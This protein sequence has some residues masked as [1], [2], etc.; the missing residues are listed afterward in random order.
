MIWTR[1]TRPPDLTV[2]I[3]RWLG[4]V[5]FEE[6]GFVRS[7]ELHFGVGAH[8]LTGTPRAWVPDHRLFDFVGA[9][10]LARAR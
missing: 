8:R 4:E 10:V 1:H 7:E 2:D 6:V 3:R 5:G 9:D